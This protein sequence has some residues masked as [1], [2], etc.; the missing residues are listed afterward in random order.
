M[1]TVIIV[2]D[3][4]DIRSGLRDIIVW[5]AYGYSVGGLARNGMEALEL[6]EKNPPDLLLTD[7]KM[8]KMDGLNLSRRF[9][10]IK[11][12]MA[13]LLLSGY[14]EFEYAKEAL[15]LGLNGYLLKPLD[16]KELIA[17]LQ[18]LDVKK[19]SSADSNENVIFTQDRNRWINDLLAYI[20]SHYNEDINILKLAEKFHF[21]EDY[22][23]KQIKKATNESF[24]RYLNLLRVNHSLHLLTETGLP[25]H[26]IS[27]LVGYKHIEHFYK[28]FYSIKKITPKKYRTAFGNIEFS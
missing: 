27:N 14:N 1:R 10:Q 13:V 23:G 4:I 7:I 22:V 18:K 25:I 15:N 17:A 9:K 19:R 6:Y 28:S 5:E 8:P 24:N 3:E 2:D 21:S 11:P 16:V 20:N 26:I 12:D